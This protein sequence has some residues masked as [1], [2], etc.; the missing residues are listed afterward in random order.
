MINIKYNVAKFLKSF[1][2]IEL[3]FLSKREL[4]Q[5]E[6]QNAYTDDKFGTTLMLYFEAWYTIVEN[7]KHLTL[8]ERQY[9]KIEKLYDMVYHF[10]ANNLYP[11]KPSEYLALLDNPK[12]KEIQRYAQEVYDSINPLI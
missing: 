3:Y 1:L 12:W 4:Q 7:R 9:L 11:T 8:S 10:Q 5:K 2:N 6:W